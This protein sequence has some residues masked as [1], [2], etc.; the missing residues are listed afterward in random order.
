[1]KEMLINLTEKAYAFKIG[2]GIPGGPSAGSEVTYK[3][4]MNAVLLFSVKIGFALAVLMII[5]AGYRYM[6]SQ[7]NQSQIGEA[8]EIFIGAI[9]GFILLLLIGVII[10]VLKVK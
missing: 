4:Y 2:V 1:M 10:S 9:I 5:F 7:G 3:Q 6:F 8:K